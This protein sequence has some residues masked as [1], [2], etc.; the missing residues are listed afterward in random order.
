MLLELRQRADAVAYNATIAAA[1]KAA[2]WVDSLVI[3]AMMEEALLQPSTTTFNANISA[4]EKSA[5][6]QASLQLCED[7][8][9]RKLA[10]DIVT[11]SAL[12]SSCE[13]GTQWTLA[14]HFFGLCRTAGLLRQREEK[15]VLLDLLLLVDGEKGQTLALKSRPF[16]VWIQSIP[17]RS[18]PSW[19][20]HA[21]VLALALVLC[22]ASGNQE[23]EVTK[24][25]SPDDDPCQ[26]WALQRQAARAPRPLELIP[27][28][29]VRGEA[30]YFSSR[31]SK[32][33][34][35]TRL[36]VSHTIIEN[37]LKAPFHNGWPTP[38]GLSASDVARWLQDELLPTSP[39]GQ[40]GMLVPW[41]EEDNDQLGH[42][43]WVGYSRRQVCYLTAK[44]YLGA[45]A[46]GYNA[47]LFRLMAMCPRTGDFRQSFATLLAACAA[48]PTLANGHQGPLLLTAKARAAPSVEEVRQ[49]AEDVSM[50][51]AQLRVC[52]YDAGAGHFDGVEPVP[53]Q[54][55]VPRTP[56][57]PGVDFMTGGLPGQATQDISASW[58]GGYLFDAHACGLGGG[59]DERLSVYFPE[60]TV[61]AYFLSQSHPF[62]QLRQPAW[63][64]GARNFFKNLD[65]TARFD[66]PLVLADV[67]LKS[68][69]VDVQVADHLFEI[70]SSRPFVV[71]MSESQGF[72]RDTDQNLKLARM[73]RLQAQREMGT[74]RFAFEK[75]VRAWY[76]SLALTSYDERIHGALRALVKSIGRPLALDYYIYADFT[77]NPGN[78]C[79]VI[80]GEAWMPRNAY[81]DGRP[82][83]SNAAICGEK[84]FADAVKAFGHQT[85]ARTWRYIEEKV[86]WGDLRRN[87][88]DILLA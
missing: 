47:G 56:N 14:L 13:K 37:A 36:E 65:G 38:F 87:V 55:C 43:G 54:G 77:E 17:P 31:E 52:D 42:G 53:G 46:H 84:G 64:L 59:Q 8:F 70:S 73:N 35:W 10:K 7:M 66:S 40:Y 12:I 71:F 19:K 2:R 23:D 83:V 85:V 25:L 28:P 67:P 22:C 62:P 9:L 30:A 1:E 49:K 82:C 68:D 63:F 48:D 27:T 16:G 21:M 41:P 15:G 34:E 58:F 57:A 6:W 88:F 76:R 45:K 26:I 33:F 5:V 44:S 86:A 24:Q 20:R 29:S 4:C 51:S 3:L 78:Q 32:S 80:P 75:Q 79:Y 72:F 61:L 60:V 50:Q 69:L 81:F 18:T 39:F 74:G 11:F